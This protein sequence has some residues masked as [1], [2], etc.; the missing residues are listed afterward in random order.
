MPDRAAL[1]GRLLQSQ[2]LRQQVILAGSFLEAPGNEHDHHKHLLIIGEHLRGNLEIFPSLGTDLHGPLGIPCPLV[3]MM[4]PIVF[5]VDLRLR[6]GKVQ[7]H[8]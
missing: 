4:T 1:V 6:V 2:W 7:K 3:A 8:Q 5:D